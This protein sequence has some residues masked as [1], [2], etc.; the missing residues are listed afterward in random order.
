[1]KQRFLVLAVL[2]L[3]IS[4]LPEQATAEVSSLTFAG[5]RFVD[6]SGQPV[7]LL[8]ANYEG[9]ADRAWRMWEDGLF[10]AELIA[11][12]LDRARAANLSVLR[13]FIQRP[14]ASDILA[15]RWAKLDKVLELADQRGLKLVLTF[16]D[17][18]EPSI[19]RLVEVDAAVAKRYRGRPTILA[20]DLKN[21]P[22]FYNL[23][24]SEYPPGVSVPLQQAS[25]VSSVGERIARQD[26]ASYRNSEEGKRDI[27][28]RLTDDQAY[29]YANALAAY[30]QFLQDAQAWAREK[31][32]TV[33]TY[34][35]S[36]DSSHWNPLEQALNETLAAWIKPRLDALR[37]NDPGRPITIGHADVVLASLPVNAWLDYRT[38]HRYPSASSEGIKASLA[39]F[40][41]L[42]ALLPARLLVLGEFGISTA[43]T[44]EQ[45]ASQLE[46][47]MVQAVRERGGAGALK[48][49][50]NDFPQGFNERENAFGVYRG[51]GSPKPVAEAFRALGKLR[52]IVPPAVR[53][54]APVL[55]YDIP[56]GHFF[57]QTNG[58]PPGTDG[59][60]FAVTNADG[61]PFWDAF[62][63]FGGVDA[64]GYPIGRRFVLDGFVVQPMQKAI[65]QW[66]PA[67][68]QVWLL[69]TFDWLHEAGKDD[70]LATAKLTPPPLDTSEDAGKPWEEVL[71]RH[72]ALLDAYPALKARYLSEPNWIDRFGLPVAVADY[73]EVSVVRGQRAVLQQWKIDT[74]WARAG[75]ITVAN[76]GDLA[77]EAGLFPLEA[78]VPQVSP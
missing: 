72:V 16:A 8:G 59:S 5:G 55:D 31:R 71:Q 50:L 1:M 15:G 17:Y 66:R 63:Q 47:E 4:A 52:A 45:R 76:G 18:G 61:I 54:G 38:I 26:I 62:Q 41:D 30:R 22:R 49:M 36:P 74:P 48:W 28:V 46:V 10:N 12:D 78:T 73:R 37:A 25:L 40:D 57:T 19:A 29:V 56:G 39:V 65:F 64:V 58:N 27:P 44:D 43:T 33:V 77:K 35:Q 67:E 7:F 70:W 51:D 42:R 20:Y 53:A 23:A 68:Q 69:N 13:I 21:E 3:L 11:K 9:P 6:G 14:L 75:Q 24:L 32:S 60:G 2:C 34:I